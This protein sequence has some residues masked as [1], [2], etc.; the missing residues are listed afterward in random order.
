VGGAALRLVDDERAVE[1]GG[2]GLA[3]H[4]RNS[5]QL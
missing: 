2:L 4:E 5:C 3:W 1:G